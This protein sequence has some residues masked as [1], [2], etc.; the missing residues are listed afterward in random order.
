MQGI[1]IPFYA[2]FVNIPELKIQEEEM[3]KKWKLDGTL[4]RSNKTNFIQ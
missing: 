3:T 4:F 1:F 2:V